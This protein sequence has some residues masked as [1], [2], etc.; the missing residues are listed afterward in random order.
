MSL[1]QK[2]EIKFRFFFHFKEII[3][4]F[5]CFKDFKEVDSGRSSSR[6]NIVYFVLKIKGLFF[7]YRIGKQTLSDRQKLI[8]TDFD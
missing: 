3:C 1:R 8:N 6:L 4:F 5:L 7:L 2:Q